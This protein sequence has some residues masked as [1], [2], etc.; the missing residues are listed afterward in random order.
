MTWRWERRCRRFFFWRCFGWGRATPRSTCSSGT[1]PSRTGSCEMNWRPLSVFVLALVLFGAAR[2]P[3]E[4]RLTEQ[5]RE[6]HFFQS[7]LNLEVRAQTT[8]MGFIAAL[9]GLRAPV[10]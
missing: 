1:S 8:Q 7:Q 10:A 3:F 9:G 2:L 4:S 5:F 6:A